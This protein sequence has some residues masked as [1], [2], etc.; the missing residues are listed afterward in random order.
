M[1]KKICFLFLI[2]LAGFSLLMACDMSA[3]I[4]RSGVRFSALNRIDR[5]TAYNLYNDP[6]DYFAYVMDRSNANADNDGYGIVCYPQNQTYLDSGDYW[7]KYVKNADELS[8]TYYTGSFFNPANPDDVFDDA[9]NWIMSDYSDAAIV[10]CHARNA[11]SMPFAPGNHPFRINADGITYSLMHN[12][13]L[14]TASRIF[15]INEI[16]LIQPGWFSTHRPNYDQFDNAEYP[17]YWI[18]T[19]VLLHFIVSHVQ[20]CDNNVFFGLRIA[21]KKLAPYLNQSSNKANFIMSDGQ[22]LYAFRSTPYTG[23]NSVYQLS[24]RNVNNQFYGVRTG[25]PISGDVVMEKNEL[26]ILSRHAEPMRYPEFL[27]H[28][29]GAGLEYNSSAGL[30][31]STDAGIIINPSQIQVSI[32]FALEHPTR[33]KLAV[34]NQ[35]GQFV[36][37]LADSRM[38]SGVHNV[39]WDGNDQNGRKSGRGVFFLEMMAGQKRTLSKIL[40]LH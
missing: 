10:M 18:D 29:Y 21:L 34:Y 38:S 33:I 31:S 9:M 37:L 40:Y 14:S 7:Y 27:T 6:Y 26:V 25:L 35:K 1:R 22:R 20:R 2:W 15:M 17:A 36:K 13:T 8:R 3:M 4:T 5:L 16:N 32:S 19:E 28:D 23:H 12:G 39:V 24:Y 30:Q 11:S